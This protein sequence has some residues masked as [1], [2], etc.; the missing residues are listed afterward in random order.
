MRKKVGLFFLGLV[1]ILVGVLWGGDSVGLWHI[2]LFFDGWWALIFIIM[3]IY[4]MI[5]HGV[6]GF[7]LIVM[8]IGF[9]VLFSHIGIVDW[10]RIRLLFWPCLV[11]L[12]GIYVMC[13]VFKKKP[14]PALE[15]EATARVSATFGAT[16]SSCDGRPYDGGVVDAAFG[17]AELDLRNA[18]IER[19]ISMKVSACFGGAKIRFPSHVRVETDN[20]SFLGGVKNHVVENTAVNAPVVRVRCSA[21]F[22]GIELY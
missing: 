13:G 6:K 21:V 19:D 5:C 10:Q 18:I 12:I 8:A 4:G 9:V 22:G 15:K 16:K 1:L 2:N 3:P 14:S 7:D 11:I 20:R 17:A